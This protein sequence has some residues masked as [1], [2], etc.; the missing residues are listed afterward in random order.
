MYA[1]DGNQFL[2]LLSELRL[3]PSLFV[4]IKWR[5]IHLR[6]RDFVYLFSYS[7]KSFNKPLLLYK[8]NRL[9]FPL[10]V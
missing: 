2:L 8:T 9:H 5:Q 10:S 1:L 4:R 3:S 7:Q 6:S